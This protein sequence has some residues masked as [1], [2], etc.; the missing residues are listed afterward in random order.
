[1]TNSKDSP[2]SARE[3]HERRSIYGRRGWP[4]LRPHGLRHPSKPRMRAALP[5]LS[6]GQTSNQEWK[7]KS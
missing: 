2:V 7:G 6:W 5:N 1:M 3:W 4:V